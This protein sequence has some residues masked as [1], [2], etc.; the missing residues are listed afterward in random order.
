ML[1]GKQRLVHSHLW[2]GFAARFEQRVVW[3]SGYILEYHPDGEVSS[4]FS[5][6]QLYA[7]QQNFRFL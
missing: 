5:S 2:L 1:S 4:A 6:G 7:G 3:K